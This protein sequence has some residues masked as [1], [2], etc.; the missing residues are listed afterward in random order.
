[1]NC[2]I[3]GTYGTMYYVNDMAKSVKYYKEIL[4]LKP[5]FES[6]EWTEFEI[7]GG[8]ALC[9]HNIEHG[10]KAFHEQGVLILDVKGLT[11]MVKDLKTKGVEFIN[12][13]KEV[14]PGAFCADFKDPSG[15]LVSFYEDTTRK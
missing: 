2:K 10:K 14:H 4:G 7:N 15:N 13:G 8:T 12:E 11:A 1:M 6:P 9:L 5:R 3:N